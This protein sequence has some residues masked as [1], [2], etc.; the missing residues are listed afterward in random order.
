MKMGFKYD[1]VIIDLTDP[2]LKKEMWA[3]LLARVMNT[4]KIRKGGFV[5]NAGLYLPWNTSDIKNLV[6]IIRDLCE[7]NPEFKYY[8]YTA[9][10]PSFSGEWTFIAVSHKCK[11]MMDPEFLTTIPEWIRR[12]IRMLPDSLIYSNLVI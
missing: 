7:K 2:D 6:D 9:F 8:V 3:N 12:S 11:F 4:V 5:M 10:I 1:A